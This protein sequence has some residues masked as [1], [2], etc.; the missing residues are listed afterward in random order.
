MARKSSLKTLQEG[1]KRNIE[2]P[3]ISKN[4]RNLQATY[5]VFRR[6]WS[7]LAT[8]GGINIREDIPYLLYNRLIFV[9]WKTWQKVWLKQICWRGYDWS[10]RWASI[11]CRQSMPTFGSFLSIIRSNDRSELILERD[12]VSIDE[13]NWMLDSFNAISHRCQQKDKAV[14]RQ[15]RGHSWRP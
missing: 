4:S 5:S 9:V 13:T 6:V 1:F 8:L 10:E 15:S 12:G 3:S 14:N 7:N 2:R 11:S